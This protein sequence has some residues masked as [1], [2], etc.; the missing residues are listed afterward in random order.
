MRILGEEALARLPTVGPGKVAKSTFKLFWKRGWFLSRWTLPVERSW[1]WWSALDPLSVLCLLSGVATSF[2]WRAETNWA[3]TGD[4]VHTKQLHCHQTVEICAIAIPWRSFQS[5]SKRTREQSL[6]GGSQISAARHQ[7]WQDFD[8]GKP[9]FLLLQL[10]IWNSHL[11]ENKVIWSKHLIWQRDES[12]E[13]KPA[14]LYYKKLPPNIPDCFVMLVLLTT[15]A[16]KYWRIL[17]LGMIFVDTLPGECI[18][19]YHPWG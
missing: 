6:T 10:N 1:V 16:P 11:I 13:D 18:N 4:S 17:S 12:K 19:K 9:W 8:S 2:R 7:C 14:V 5:K 3:S 15:F